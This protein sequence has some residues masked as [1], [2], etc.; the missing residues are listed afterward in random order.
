MV[1]LKRTLFLDTKPLSNLVKYIFTGNLL[2]EQDHL[3]PVYEKLKDIVNG[4][5][6]EAMTSEPVLTEAVYFLTQNFTDKTKEIRKIMELLKSKEINVKCCGPDCLESKEFV[7]NLSYPD[8]S[9]MIC[10]LESIRNNVIS[11]MISS[12]QTL[13]DTTNDPHHGGTAFTPIQI[14]ASPGII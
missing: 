1:L 6:Y 11:I 9:I 8:V 4:K 3:L 2:D 7:K 10:E 14:L 13:V 12:D 5:R